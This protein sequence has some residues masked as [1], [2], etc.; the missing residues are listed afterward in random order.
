MSLEVYLD[1]K[2]EGPVSFPSKLHPF[3]CESRSCEF[4]VGYFRSVYNEWG[5]NSIARQAGLRTLFDIF[6]VTERDYIVFPDWQ[7]AQANARKAVEEW[8]TFAATYVHPHDETLFNDHAKGIEIV[9]ETIDWVLAHDDPSDFIM[10]W[11]G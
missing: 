2:R 4:R 7:K 6:N 8:Q 5:L 11:S 10:R 3:S 1:H 9:N